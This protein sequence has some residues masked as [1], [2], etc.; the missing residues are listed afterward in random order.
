VLA[1]L[2][3]PREYE[4]PKL[5]LSEDAYEAILDQERCEALEA[6]EKLEKLGH[7]LQR[8]KVTANAGSGQ[9]DPS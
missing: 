4:P 1:Q 9:G 5:A 7:E 8:S 2:Y 3:A 6:L